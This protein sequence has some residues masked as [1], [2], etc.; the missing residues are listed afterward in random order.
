MRSGFATKMVS[1]DTGTTKKYLRAEFTSTAEGIYSALRRRVEQ[2]MT[3]KCHSKSMAD[4]ARTP[5]PFA[6]R[7]FLNSQSK[8]ADKRIYHLQK[9][10]EA[11]LKIEADWNGYGSEP[12]NA[13]AI[14][15]AKQAVLSGAKFNLIPDRAVASTS[16]GAG[17]CFYA[18]DR[19]ADL[20]FFNTGEIVAMTS[21]GRNPP[22]VWELTPDKIDLA[23]TTIREYLS[24]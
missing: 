9:S 4:I 10:L 12:P 24:A 6:V 20:E 17:I 3:L 22:D 15:L 11:L 7:R 23:L 5:A 18:R 2:V 16:G 19:Y 14:A 1:E 8:L 13:L 21:D